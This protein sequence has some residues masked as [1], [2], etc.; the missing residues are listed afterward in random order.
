MTKQEFI[1]AVKNETLDELNFEPFSKIKELFI[2]KEYLADY[3]R[4]K[5]EYDYNN[6]KSLKDSRW[7]D[8]LHPILIKL[9]KLNRK[10]IDKQNLT[11]LNDARQNNKKTISQK[12]K[13][14]IKGEKKKPVIYAITHI[15]KYDFQI[16]SEAIKD[17]Q[18]PFAGDPETMYRNFDGLVLGLNGVIYCDTES[19]TDRKIAK[20]TSIDLLNSGKNLLIYPEGVWNVTSNLLML[21]LFPGIIEMAKETGCDIVPVAI[22]RYDKDY[23]VN[24][25]AEFSVNQKLANGLNEDEIKTDLRDEMAT[26]R[27]N[28]MES[29]PKSELAEERYFNIKSQSDEEIYLNTSRSEL[30]SY[31]EEEKKFKNERLNEWTNTKTKT[32]Y[33]NWELIKSRTFKEKDKYTG[34]R[35]NIPE[36][37]FSYF[38]KV[39]LKKNNIFM[40]PS[41]KSLPNET[42]KL[43]DE[44]LQNSIPELLDDFDQEVKKVA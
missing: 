26:L 25:G 1:E 41:D 36:D 27:W 12:V 17:H 23:I 20:E 37:V 5:R 4:L 13:S 38:R 34:Y 35:V 44:N 10:Y 11:I 6:G 30:S 33:Y 14:F 42:Q 19:K 3:Y 15:D 28:I 43:L 16:V 22:E 9:V 39:K 24:I 7:R 21:P 18:Y 8:M 40:F 2:K 32:P 29:L 31:D